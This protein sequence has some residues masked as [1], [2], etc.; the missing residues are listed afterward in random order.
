MT[1]SNKFEEIVKPLIVLIGICL[2][3]SVLLGFTHSITA[4]IIES[5]GDAQADQTRAEVL[6]GATSFTKIKCDTEALGIDSA[7]K[8][9]SGLGYVITASNKGYGGSVVVMVGIDP[10]GT[11]VGLS[12]D[13]STETTGIG[14]KAGEAEYTDKY[15]GASGTADVDTI[16]G[17][18]KSS[19]AV[20]A[21][22]NAALAAFEAVKGE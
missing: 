15:I 6:E 11:V 19:S 5:S 7:Y 21:G 9:K 20:K 13:V 22:V 8:E 2:V 3:V 16:S 10:N 14:S 18:T 1:K 4:P 17:A 12:V